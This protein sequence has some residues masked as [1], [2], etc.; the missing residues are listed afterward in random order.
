MLT[1]TRQLSGKFQWTIVVQ[2]VPLLRLHCSI[3]MQVHFV[4]PLSTPLPPLLQYNPKPSR[5]LGLFGLSLYTGE[6]DLKEILNKY[7]H[8]ERVQVVYD[9]QVSK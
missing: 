7:G 6:K 4:P 3:L 5:V 8:L 2:G 1:Q 9:H